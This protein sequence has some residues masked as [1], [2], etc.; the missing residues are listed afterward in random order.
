MLLSENLS[1]WWA[2]RTRYH[3]EG[4]GSSYSKIPLLVEGL[5]APGA[6]MMI[7]HHRA[8]SGDHW[9]SEA[10]CSLKSHK[11][12]TNVLKSMGYRLCFYQRTITWDYSHNDLGALQCWTQKTEFCMLH[13]GLMCS[14][15]TFQFMDP[16]MLKQCNL[17]LNSSLGLNCFSVRIWWYNCGGTIWL[18]FLVNLSDCLRYLIID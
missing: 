2:T 18:S 3:P 8:T 10:V 17:L 9:G 4:C 1:H 14:E 5:G 15:F 11:C 12:L 6:G 13:I 7:G 16:N